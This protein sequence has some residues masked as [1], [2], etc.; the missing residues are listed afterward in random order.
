MVS[1]P[2]RRSQPLPWSFP[3]ANLWGPCVFQSQENTLRLDLFAQLQVGGAWLK[4][5]APAPLLLI[6]IKTFW[7]VTR[8]FLNNQASIQKA[9]NFSA[10]KKSTSFQKDTNLP[11]TADDKR[12][13]HLHHR[14]VYGLTDLSL[15]PGGSLPQVLQQV[16]LPILTQEECEAALL[17]LRNPV[18]G[19]TFL[20]TGSPD[21]GRDACQ[22]SGCSYAPGPG[23]LVNREETKHADSRQTW[24]PFFTENSRGGPKDE[25]L[26]FFSPPKDVSPYFEVS[27]LGVWR[28]TLLNSWHYE[29]CGHLYH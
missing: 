7:W 28:M 21:G 20:C 3:Q 22:V 18:T 15:V 27:R 14:R 23:K 2:A 11:L 26:R 8:K 24:N 16:N 9:V 13:G 19:K 6:Q 1:F 25:V 10:F 12:T 17:S 5:R 29:D 4:V